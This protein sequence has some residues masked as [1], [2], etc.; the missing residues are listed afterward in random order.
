MENALTHQW[1]TPILISLIAFFIGVIGFMIRSYMESISSNVREIK[2]DL[3]KHVEKVEKFMV[4]MNREH[5]TM[6]KRITL[7]EHE[8]SNGYGKDRVPNARQGDG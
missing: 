3:I 6:D 5:G 1:L 8:I 2:L 4:D 7:I